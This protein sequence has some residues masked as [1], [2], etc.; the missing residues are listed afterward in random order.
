M[1]DLSGKVAIVSGASRGIGRAYALALAGAGVKVVA[2]ARTVDGDPSRPGSLAELVATARAMGGEVVARACDIGDEAGIVEAV[3]QT[4]ADHGGVDIL[5]NN[6]IWP[7]RGFDALEVSLEEWA[8]TFRLNVGG[9]Y[10]FM[11]EVVP[12]MIARGGGSIINMTTASAQE[13]TPGTTNHGY[14]AYAVTKAG[15]ERLTTYFAAEF[16]DRKIAVNA[17]SPGNVSRYMQRTGRQPDLRFWGEPILH[18]AQA[19]PG[20]GPTG[21]V[22][23]TYEFGRSWGPKPEAPPHWDEA[24]STLLREFGLAG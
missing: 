7:I 4:V 21:Q 5:L 14:P 18:L 19:R 3:R 6:A 23:H 20:D 17:I 24:I 11:R 22:L 12:Q 15:L 2:L 9:A 1:A 10:V 13:S 16:E 8:T